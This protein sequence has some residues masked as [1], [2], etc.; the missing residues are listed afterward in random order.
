MLGVKRPLPGSRA[1][2]FHIELKGNASSGFYVSG[3]SF[4]NGR[5]TLVLNQQTGFQTNEEELS[6]WLPFLAEVLTSSWDRTHNLMGAGDTFQMK[7]RA[8]AGLIARHQEEFAK[9]LADER[10]AIK[11]GHEESNTLGSAI[12]SLPV[13]SSQKRLSQFQSS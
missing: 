10:A 12:A 6:R 7:G 11:N 13:Q 5:V 9:L 2:P 4:P 1:V 3:W 8:I